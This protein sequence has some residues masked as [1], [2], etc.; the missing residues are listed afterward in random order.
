MQEN[1]RKRKLGALQRRK[2]DQ[3]KNKD[4]QRCIFTVQQYTSKVDDGL[5]KIVI[6]SSYTVSPQDMWEAMKN[7]R[8]RQIECRRKRPCEA[9]TKLSTDEDQVYRLQDTVFLFD[10]RGPR[11]QQRAARILEIRISDEDRKY[12]CLLRFSCSALTTLCRRWF[13]QG[14]LSTSQGRD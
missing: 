12:I 11:P 2:L 3:E 13:H 5:G 1:H 9:L 6:E 14:L 4:P 10:H 8:H 7:G